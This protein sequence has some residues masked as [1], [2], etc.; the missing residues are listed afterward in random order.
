M[1]PEIDIATM[2]S[3]GP[4]AGPAVVPVLVGPLQALIA[5]L[6]AIGVALATTVVA[7]F[8]PSF[9]IK[10]YPG[11]TGGKII[12]EFTNKIIQCTIASRPLSPAHGDHIKTF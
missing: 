7:M 12:S 6:P 8:K 5:M 11:I 9:I 3:A 10:D 1:T 4:P 2:L